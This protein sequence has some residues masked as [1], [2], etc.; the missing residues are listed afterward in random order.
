[1]KQW[2]VE[3]LLIATCVL[4]GAWVIFHIGALNERRVTLARQAA[5]ERAAN[6][7]YQAEVERGQVAASRYIAADRAKQAQLE[8]LTEQFDEL[9]KRVPLVITRPGVTAARTAGPGPVVALA[10]VEN[11]TPSPVDLVGPGLSAGAVWMWNSALAGADMPAGACGAADTATEPCAADTGL[12]LEAAWRNHETNART[13]ASDRR[14]QQALIDFLTQR[15]P[16][17]VIQ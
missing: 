14:R 8:T 1:M 3:T 13:C 2:L 9:R 11:S 15:T 10:M 4:G 7:K 16:V 12:G 17:E 5:T 6:A